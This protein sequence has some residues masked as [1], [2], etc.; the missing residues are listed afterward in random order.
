MYMRRK[1]YVNSSNNFR[2]GDEVKYTKLNRK[3]SFPLYISSILFVIFIIGYIIWL[4]SGFGNDYDTCAHHKL[5]DSSQFCAFSPTTLRY[6]CTPASPH[7]PP[8]SYEPL[9]IT[10]PPLVTVVIPCYDCVV[11]G[12]KEAI[13]SILNQ[14]LQ[15]FEVILVDDGSSSDTSSEL[16]TIQKSI[17]LHWFVVCV[18]CVCVVWCCDVW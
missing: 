16:H 1:E 18:W 10:T 17:G 4:F 13:Y 14:S 11:F 12:L 8:F 6:E 2:D 15:E 7:R 5:V 9:S 3:L